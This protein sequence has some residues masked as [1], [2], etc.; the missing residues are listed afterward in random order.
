MRRPVAARRI[1]LFLTLLVILGVNTAAS[2]FT[3]IPPKEHGGLWDVWVFH[4][5]DTWYLFYGGAKSGFGTARS[6]DG[7]HW[8][9]CPP[10]SA[11]GWRGGG[12]AFT[13]KSPNFAK[14]GKYQCDRR[15]NVG[16]RPAIVITES[17]DL[18]NWKVRDKVYYHPDPRWYSQK[19]RW[20]CISPVRRPGGGYYGY[21]TATAKGGSR[22]CIGYGETLDGVAWK[23]LAPANIKWGKW[24]KFPAG[25][26]ELGGAEFIK[27]KY[28]L[29]INLS[30]SKGG[31]S[32]MIAFS[33]DK[34]EGPFVAT[35]KN[36]EVVY[37][38]VHFS[39]FGR[40]AK[41]ILVVQ[42]YLVREKNGGGSG[43]RK[44]WD[45]T[46]MAPMKEALV[47]K[48]GTLRL[49]YW[50]GNEA[51]KGKAVRLKTP[52]LGK[53]PALLNHSFNVRKGFVMEGKIKLPQ[54][55]EE[56]L[57]GIYLES[58]EKRPTV[59]Q[60]TAKGTSRIGTAK[61]DGSDFQLRKSKI[62]WCGPAEVDREM[63]FGPT[64]K[65]RLL[66]RKSMME[67][68]MDD[69]LFHI[70][71]LKYAPTGKVGIVGTRGSLSDLK[72]WDMSFDV[73]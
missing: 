36:A 11:A 63:K 65:F 52:E 47:D 15:I 13:W 34:P 29:M 2:G 9:E 56:Q 39:R 37:G 6:K 30:D 25:W 66:V 33:C 54:A 18:L 27:G 40:S 57:P 16:G 58:G 62:V 48:D 45:T 19:A 55:G 70:R 3:F 50:K 21:C 61:K 24:G 4:A 12:S 60:A 31:G 5:N 32:R 23:S 35:K 49:G 72:A 42:H 43:W 10:V 51:L 22:W 46:Y 44:N 14:D 26:V 7:V 71:A 67:F 69:I 20:I 53:R 41:E 17:T 8:K 64:V 59:L 1:G 73:K 28:Y 38:D 68:Y